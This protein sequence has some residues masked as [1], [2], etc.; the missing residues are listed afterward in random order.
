[1]IKAQENYQEGFPGDKNPT[2][3]DEREK[4]EEKQDEIKLHT[5]KKEGLRER[6]TTAINKK[7]FL[8]FFE[9]SRGI[10]SIACQK[11]DISRSIYYVW[12]KKDSK[13]RKAVE[14]ITKRRPEVLEDRMY[15]KAQEGDIS[16]LKFMLEYLHPRFKKPVQKQTTVHIHH[17]STP[18]SEL[19]KNEEINLDL[20]D[21]IALADYDPTENIENQTPAMQKL[22][23]RYKPLLDFWDKFRG[24]NGEK[25]PA[26]GER[27]K[28]L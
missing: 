19:E 23:K 1:M 22:L 13:F 18:P 25:A 6:E 7:I 9:R 12:M 8:D 28:N 16:A 26:D 4:L 20:C 2:L 10:V 11:I 15:A 17:H 5:T 24:D 27:F 21:L 3:K 14:E